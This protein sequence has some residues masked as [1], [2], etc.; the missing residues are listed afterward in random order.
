MKR[1]TKLFLSVIR[2]FF[3]FVYKTYNGEIV[4]IK[5]L[6]SIFYAS[7][8]LIVFN[9]IFNQKYYIWVS[10]NFFKFYSYDY[11]SYRHFI[12]L[13]IFVFLYLVRLFVYFIIK[14][15]LVSNYFKNN[16]INTFIKSNNF[17][18]FTQKLWNNTKVYKNLFLLFTYMK[19]FLSKIKLL[20][21]YVHILFKKVF[22]HY[23]GFVI[24]SDTTLFKSCTYHM[25][26]FFF[27]FW[28][29]LFKKLSY[30][31]LFKSYRSKWFWKN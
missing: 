7:L 5:T 20:F 26:K 18:F 28:R 29:P 24:K 23:F 10:I 1:Y 21:N 30:F 22:L 17:T 27:I 3:L 31:G 8:F 25:F 6:K 9:T 11:S 14:I 19:L 4:I 13:Y 15:D 12:Y 16:K 2:W